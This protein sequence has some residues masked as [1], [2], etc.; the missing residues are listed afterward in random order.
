MIWFVNLSTILHN[1]LNMN[2]TQAKLLARHFAQPTSGE[3]YLLDIHSNQ[4]FPLHVCYYF[5]HHLETH[6]TQ[7]NSFK[8]FY[9][10]HLQLNH[11]QFVL[12]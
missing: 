10:S 2:L 7:H 4:L 11:N 9:E 5:F 8:H 3:P 6:L 1:D 12:Y